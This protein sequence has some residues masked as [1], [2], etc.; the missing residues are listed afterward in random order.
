MRPAEPG[1]GFRLLRSLTF[2]LAL[3]YL[4]IFTVSVAVLI[5]IL[6]WA[7]VYVPLKQVERGLEQEVATLLASSSSNQEII[8]RLGVRAA[9]PAERRAFQL[10]ASPDGEILASNLPQWPERRSRDGWQRFEFEVFEADGADEFE[11]LARDVVL[12]DGSRLLLGRNTEDLDEREELLGQ[13]IGW[14]TGVTLLTGLIGALLMTRAVGLRIESVRSTAEQVM[15]GDLSRRVELTGSGDD[16]DRLAETLNAMLARI[17][18]L[19]ESVRRVSDSVAHEL[20]TPLTHLRTDLEELALAERTDPESSALAEQALAGARKLQSTFDALLRIARV[21]TGQL[22]AGFRLVDLT[23]LLRDV[24]DL[25]QPAT[26]GR[27]QRMETQI[28]DGL[29]VKGDPDLLFQAVANLLDNAVKHG[30]HNGSILLSAGRRANYVDIST[31]D[32]GPG[33]P[34]KDRERVFDRFY[35][36]SGSE[37]APGVGLG[38]SLVRSVAE[39]HGG[40]VRFGEPAVG[41]VA[42]LSLPAA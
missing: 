37:P 26:E 30:P 5:T 35:R 33:V 15:T 11:V 39:L 24:A 40:S 1:G 10:L 16:F 3:V 4:A 38:L 19:M 9:A 29:S 14:G 20:R 22:R 8:Q 6:Y 32:S 41:S 12:P 25:Y 42:I 7:S 18:A 21:D 28:A 36:V 31:F 23:T 27:G 34:Q 13:A 2:R 17:E